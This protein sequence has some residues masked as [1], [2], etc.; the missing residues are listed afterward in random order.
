MKSTLTLVRKALGTLLREEL[1]ARGLPVEIV[2]AEDGR[3]QYVIGG[4]RLSPGQAA[5]YLGIKW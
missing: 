5:E 1:T 3:M 4:Q 2:Y